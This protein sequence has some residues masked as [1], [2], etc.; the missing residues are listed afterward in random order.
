MN[1]SGPMERYMSVYGRISESA[2]VIENLGSEK[3]DCHQTDLV[4][5]VNDGCKGD[6]QARM[7]NGNDF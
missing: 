4:N 5:L 7:P 2:F 6:I 3:S 1:Y